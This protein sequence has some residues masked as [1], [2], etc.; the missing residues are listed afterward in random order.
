MKIRSFRGVAL[1][2]AL[3]FVLGTI[4]SSCNKTNTPS[5][6][7]NGTN[8]IITIL[9][10]ASDAT[11]FVSALARVHLDTVLN[12]TGPYTLFAPTN[13]ALAASGVTTA[14]LNSL[15]DDS[16]KKI[17]L[18]HIVGANLLSGGLPAGPNAKLIAGNGDSIF[19]TKNVSGIFINGFP[20]ITGDIV[21]SNG[22]I[23]A[24][25]HILLPAKGN[26]IETLQSD[27]SFT[28]ILAAIHRASQGSTNL[29]SL[30]S[31]GGIYTLFAPINSGFRAAGF[32]TIDDINNLP[33]DSAANL[34]QYHILPSR[35]F[36]S[37]MT[38]TQSRVTLNGSNIVFVSTS[39]QMQIQGNKN[40][41][42]ANALS[43]NVVTRNGVLFAIDKVLLP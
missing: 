42:A 26:I 16:L 8:S 30:L 22:V 12:G 15:P 37:D 13:D 35:T 41:G 34:V 32:A 9:Q 5:N 43:V 21:A 23:D 4:I 27:T 6:N 31:V 14:Y 25:S 33:A 7:N 24:L 17:L 40:N 2:L 19:V 11:V 18:Y 3:I 28:Y 10:G 39:G 36:T 38:N 1:F 29:D 20:L